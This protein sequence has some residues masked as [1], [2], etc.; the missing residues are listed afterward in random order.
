MTKNLHSQGQAHIKNW[1]SKITHA[2]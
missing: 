2:T 1:S